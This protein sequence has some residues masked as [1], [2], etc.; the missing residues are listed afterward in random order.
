[1]LGWL[2]TPA[3]REQVLWPETKRERKKEK[4]SYSRLRMRETGKIRKGA[5]LIIY[6]LERLS[7]KGER[8]SYGHTFPQEDIQRSLKIKRSV[9]LRKWKV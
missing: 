5:H 9:V 1:M 4:S 7:E 3:V 8:D 2:S 6:Y